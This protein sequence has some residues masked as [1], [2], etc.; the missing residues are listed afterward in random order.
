MA[1]RLNKYLA[2]RG[3]AARRKCDQLIE[4]GRVTLNGKLVREVGIKIDEDRD[5]VAVDGHNVGG[6]SRTVYYVLNKPVG[7]ITTLDD[8]QGRRTIREFL[9]R[10]ARVYPVGRLDADTSGLLLLTNDGELA[11]KLMHPRYG[12]QKVYRVRLSQEPRGDQLRRLAA[13]V[14]FDKGLVSGPARVRRIDPGFDAIM[15]ELIIHEGRFRQVRKMCEA[16]GLP[17]AGLHRVGYGPIRLGPMSKGMF[18]ELSEEEVTALRAAASRPGG[19]GPRTRAERGD[20]PVPL[21]GGKRATRP[22]TAVERP[23]RAAKPTPPIDD[24]EIDADEPDEISDAW[25]A[26]GGFIPRDEDDDAAPQ[27]ASASD[28]E[29]DFDDE[30][31]EDDGDG[32]T[33]IGGQAL[34]G[35]D[36]DD[37]DDDGDDDVDVEVVD[38]EEIEEAGASLSESAAWPARADRRRGDAA[39]QAEHAG[40]TKP[41]GRSTPGRPA[42]RP[43]GRPQGRPQGR[44]PGDGRPGRPMA[45][46]RAE[47]PAARSGTGRS[48]TRDRFDRPAPRTG[49]SARGGVA[50]PSTGERREGGRPSGPRREFDRPSAGPRGGRP[51]G[52][53]PAGGRPAG[54]RPS[55]GRP[56]GPPRR[57]FDRPSAGSPRGGRPAG[58]RPA[59]GR[60]SGP[61]REF[62]RPSA[63]GPRREF[64]DSGRPRSAGRSTGPRPGGGG[65]RPAPKR[66]LGRPAKAGP[67]G[68]P[69]KGAK[70]GAFARFVRPERPGRA[71]GARAGGKP[72]SRAGGGAGRPAS[73]SGKPTSGGPRRG[74]P[75]KRGRR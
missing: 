74:A 67:G 49:A 64:N 48:A 73:R 46:D 75:P 21:D 8:P 61:R 32:V 2:D 72:Q 17:V 44:P 71:E 19:T 31:D 56:S 24:D 26:G 55:G 25:V 20:R 54:G 4:E 3:V 5:R 45:R 42:G 50:R 57:E 18:R 9:P 12:V 53:R 16:V 70:G 47:R 10:G 28:A 69:A 43:S 34:S 41:R 60:P 63:G 33:Y 51:A 22:E 30:E 52:G 68:R 29:F 27:G 65:G 35:S 11:H 13:G 23:V 66:G 6:R 37:D 62:D 36:D 15:I 7:V 38:D 58:G 40:D 1:V 59:G 14:R 39:W